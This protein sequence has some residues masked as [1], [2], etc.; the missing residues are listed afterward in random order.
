MQLYAITDRRLFPGDETER[1]SALLEQACRWAQA[2]VGFIQLREKD[3]CGEELLALARR[4]VSA[5]RAESGAGSARTRVLINAAG[6]GSAVARMAGADGLHFGGRVPVVAG[7]GVVSVACH[8]V[9]EV[10]EARAVG[11][12]LVVFAPVF[13]KPL[14][15][16][17]GAAGHLDGV[18][19]ALLREAC[20]AAGEMPVYALGGV[21]VANADACVEAGAAGV[22]GGEIVRRA[23]L[24]K[25]VAVRAQVSHEAAHCIAPIP[26]TLPATRTAESGG[27]GARC[28]SGHRRD[29]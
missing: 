6:A 14:R 12:S 27:V 7:V 18:G 20:V 2:G 13:E 16:V 15:E 23:E 17:D 9:E 28:R 26:S 3:L 24:G 22:A 11:A 5:V 29:A 19:L 10:V 8:N 1:Q 25:A 4:L 21:T